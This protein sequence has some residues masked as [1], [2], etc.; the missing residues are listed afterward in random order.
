[1]NEVRTCFE[2]DEKIVDAFLLN[3]PSHVRNQANP[4]RS[5]I[6]QEFVEKIEHGVLV[7]TPTTK[8]CLG[9]GPHVALVLFEQRGHVESDVTEMLDEVAA[10]GGIDKVHQ[11]IAT[12]GP[13]AYERVEDLIHL[14]LAIDERA[15]V[16]VLIQQPACKRYWVSYV[17][18]ELRHTEPPKRA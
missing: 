14:V 10:F 3:R 13:F 5:G 9:P 2:F 17:L 16:T 15:D 7:E 11:F 12:R 6:D 1:V 4:W 18:I 8:I